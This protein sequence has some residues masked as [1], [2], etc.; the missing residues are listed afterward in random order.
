MSITPDQHTPLAIGMQWNESYLYCDTLT[1]HQVRGL[2]TRGRINQTPTYHTNSGFTAD[3]RFLVFASIREGGTWLIRAEVATGEL[4]ALWHTAGIGDRNYLHRGMDLQFADSDG[5]GFCGNRVCM[6]PHAGIAVFTVERSLRAVDIASGAQR[7]LLADCG[8]EWI[9]GAPCVSPDEQ[10]VAITLSSAHPEM[11]EAE[12]M[13]TLNRHYREYP[14]RLRILR[15]PMDGSG[16]AE[17]IYQH[18]APAQ[19]AHCAFNPI[20]NNLLYFD[21]DLP[22]HYWGGSDGKTPRIWLLDIAT[23]ATRSLKHHYPGTFQTHQAWL[24][25]GSGMAYHGPRSG[26]GIYLGIT[27]ID[28]TTRWEYEVPT[29]SSYGHLTP[30]PLRSALILD[31]DFSNDLLQWLYYDLDNPSQPPRLEPI[32]RHATE[33]N[34]LPGQY[35][36]PHPLVDASGQWISFTAAQQGT[37]QVFVADTLPPG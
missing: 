35:A 18:P 36:H 31:G 16:V 14:H 37:S 10:Y 9:Y 28:G 32:C 19:S 26:G 25:D 22:P 20:D 11:C 6:A 34:S 8:E 12:R 15:V 30:D 29:A 4:T 24:W 1:G 33:W 3:G 5:R 17:V 7:V 2:T 27:A 23:S 21:L 13:H